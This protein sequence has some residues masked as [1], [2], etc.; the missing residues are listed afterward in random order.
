MGK[1]MHGVQTI[2]THI[3]PKSRT[4]SLKNHPVSLK[5]GLLK[6]KNYF[7]MDDDES[8]YIDFQTVSM[9]IM[10]N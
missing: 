3:L 9:A 6:S 7:L 2:A 1:S 5:T 4:A 10:E 8:P